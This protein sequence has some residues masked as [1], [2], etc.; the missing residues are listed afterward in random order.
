[1]ISLKIYSGV[2]LVRKNHQRQKIK[3]ARFHHWPVGFRPLLLDFDDEGQN[4]VAMAR[5]HL[6]SPE[7]G[8]VQADSCEGSRNQAI[9]VGF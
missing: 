7:S 4:L 6:V 3:V 9:C 1:M 2:S 8:L 5:F